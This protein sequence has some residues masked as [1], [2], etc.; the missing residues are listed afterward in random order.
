MITRAELL[1]STP[2]LGS[3]LLLSPAQAQAGPRRRL[4]RQLKEQLEALHKDERRTLRLRSRQEAVVRSTHDEI[5]NQTAKLKSQLSS[6]REKAAAEEAADALREQ[7]K[8]VHVETQQ[9]M[10][11]QLQM[12]RTR[13]AETE[14]LIED[15]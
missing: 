6:E 1:K 3:I 11:E 13:I 7:A 8:V 10:T 2:V 9:V 4:R 5:T 14:R 15:V 12:L